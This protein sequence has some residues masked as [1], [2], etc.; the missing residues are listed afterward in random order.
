MGEYNEMPKVNEWGDLI[1]GVTVVKLFVIVEVRDLHA[2]WATL[3]MLKI[4][5]GRFYVGME[6]A[7]GM[8]VSRVRMI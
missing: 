8:I 7:V 4:R 5:L 1:E 3:W 2:R 6:D